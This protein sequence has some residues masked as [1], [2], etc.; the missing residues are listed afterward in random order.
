MISEHYRWE[1]STKTMNEIV[2]QAE[3]PPVTIIAIRS[4]TM[5]GD[6]S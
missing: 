4:N 1:I 3:A 2:V 5:Y 6:H